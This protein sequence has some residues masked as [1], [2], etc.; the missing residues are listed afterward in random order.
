MINRVVMVG[1]L[2]TTTTGKSV[3][4]F[5]IAVDRFVAGGEREADFFTV[6]AWGQS[7]EFV[8]NY[9]GKGRLVGVD[10]RLQTRS[11]TTQDGA[12]RRETEIIADRVRGL[13]R[14][15]DT[16]PEEGQ[17]AEDQYEDDPFASE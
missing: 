10:G 16:E 13:D 14:P 4:S 6:V 12:T 3:A 15:R 5:R 7:A 2:R 8:S 9:L 17:P 11:W 1:R